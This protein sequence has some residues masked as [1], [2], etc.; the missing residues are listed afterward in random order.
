MMI[1]LALTLVLLAM[2]YIGLQSYRQL[3]ARSRQRE[4]ILFGFSVPE[5]EEE[6]DLSAGDYGL[7][8]S[9]RFYFHLRKF[10]ATTQGRVSLLLLGGLLGATASVLLGKQDSMATYAVLS[11]GV[12]L[13]LCMFWLLKYQKNHDSMVKEEL[14]NL[15]ETVA[16]IME[17]GVAFESALNFVLQ[18]SDPRHPLYFELNIMNEAMLRGRRRNEALRLWAG[19]S[20]VEAVG[21]VASGMIQADQTGAS[22]GA[23]MR[24]HA[25]ALL[26]ENEAET[27]RK[28]ERLP[29]RMLLPMASM[30]LPAVFI[31]AAGPSII[32]VFQ[33]ID[34][35]IS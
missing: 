9:A 15:L 32:R 10:I 14:P 29:I 30:I 24:H 35:I 25:Q 7:E 6:A 18:E 13:L 12:L 27:Q 20:R 34:E 22:L 2:V 23:V 17:S 11:G 5:Q 3:A 21:D 4:R 33:I 19:R 28:A 31:L 8:G 16:A 1:L 26:R